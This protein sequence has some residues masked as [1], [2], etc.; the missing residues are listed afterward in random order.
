VTEAALSVSEVL[1]GHAERRTMSVTL[2]M[3]AWPA[4]N[5]PRDIYLLAR[6]R[7]GGTLEIVGWD[8]ANRGLCVDDE[9]AHALSIEPELDSLRESGRLTCP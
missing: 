7:D 5:G 1:I 6:K 9:T 2:R 3:T 4:P 8:Y